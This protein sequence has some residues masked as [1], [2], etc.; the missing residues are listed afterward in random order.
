MYICT[1]LNMVV[2][3]L[4]TYSVQVSVRVLWHVIVEDNVDSFDI[5]AS[6]KQIRSH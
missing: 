3:R 5:H 6:S 1:H 4:F 2:I